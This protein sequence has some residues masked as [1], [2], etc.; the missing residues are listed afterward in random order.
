VYI[1]NWTTGSGSYHAASTGDSE[2]VGD[3]Y[4]EATDNI[5]SGAVQNV[6]Y[7]NSSG[8]WHLGWPNALNHQENGSPG[9][10]FW[11]QPYFYYSTKLNAPWSC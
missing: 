9:Q 11:Y 7:W 3:E 8:G 5:E 4:T 6:G 10:G 2:Y 1:N